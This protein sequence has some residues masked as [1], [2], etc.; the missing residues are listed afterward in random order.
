MGGKQKKKTK[1]NPD[2]VFVAYHICM[3]VE[4]LEKNSLTTDHSLRRAFGT[5]L[6]HNINVCISRYS[7]LICR[8]T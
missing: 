7:S 4:T 3:Y 5:Q 1:N 2:Q 6:T 8:Y